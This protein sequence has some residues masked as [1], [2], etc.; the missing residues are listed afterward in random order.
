MEIYKNIEKWVINPDFASLPDEDIRK[1]LYPVDNMKEKVTTDYL[2][3]LAKDDNINCCGDWQ[4]WYWLSSITFSKAWPIS[5]SQ[6]VGI[7]ISEIN[8][9]IEEN[10]TPS[11][12]INVIP[13][14]TILPG[15]K[16]N[17]LTP[18]WVDEVIVEKVLDKNWQVIEKA[19][20]NM[21][22]VKIQ[23]NKPLKRYEILFK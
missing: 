17:I 19:T 14:D 1:K 21:P 4:I 23:F 2:I 9:F 18:K 3:D 15:D 10:I 20:C 11:K 13:K 22:I 6:Y 12:I 8:Q 7:T 16:L 5:P